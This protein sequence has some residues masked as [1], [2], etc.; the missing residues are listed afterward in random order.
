MPHSLIS[1]PHA[2]AHRFGLQTSPA[3]LSVSE[4]LDRSTTLC[5]GQATLPVTMRMCMRRFTRLTDAFS[6][7]LENHGATVALY[8][9]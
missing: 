3:P 1:L 2:S 9:V 6:K 4:A 7:T 8:F 5:H